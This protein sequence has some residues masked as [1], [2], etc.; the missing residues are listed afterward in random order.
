VTWFDT[1]DSYGTGNLAGRAEELLG[2]FESNKRRVS[3]FT[4]LAPYPWRL[5]QASM[6]GACKESIQRLGR[7]VDVLQLHWPPSLR[8]QEKSYLDAFN[9]LV[10]TG[11]AR[12]LGVSNYGPKNLKRVLA[13]TK[14]NSNRILSNQVGRQLYS[15]A[16][17]YIS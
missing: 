4:K 17:R 16:P 10:D 2:K 15:C 8:W 11:S 7:P 5:G 9:G 14:G 3:V 12:Q 13:L 6:Q 1:A